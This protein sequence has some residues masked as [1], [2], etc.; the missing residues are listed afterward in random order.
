MFISKSI[1]HFMDT[2]NFFKWMLLT[3]AVYVLVAVIID[4]S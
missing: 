1:F 4:S 2:L 3:L